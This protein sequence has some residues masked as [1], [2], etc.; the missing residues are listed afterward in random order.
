MKNE[1]IN[2]FKCSACGLEDKNQMHFMQCIKFRHDNVKEA[3][4]IKYSDIFSED[5][6]K[7]KHVGK[8]FKIKDK[9][10]V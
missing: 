4:E 7:M 10:F 2:D 6:S 9:S 8:L 3:H 5:I 1:N